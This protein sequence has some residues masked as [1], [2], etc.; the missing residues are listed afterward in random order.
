MNG[1]K[2]EEVIRSLI[3]SLQVAKIYTISHP[4][5]NDSI[6][7]TYLTFKKNLE[8]KK[9]LIIGI[10]GEEFATDREIFFELSERAKGIIE[11]FKSKGIE[12]IAFFRDLSKEELIK[13]VSF[14]TESGEEL[15]RKD[16]EKYLS[17]LGIKNIVIGKIK[18]IAPL[19]EKEEILDSINYL[20]N[21]E[22]SLQK[23]AQPVEAVISKKDF[24]EIDL[25]FTM[26]NIFEKLVGRY[27]EF[28]KLT[29][30]KK[31]DVVTFVHLLN[32]SILSMYFSKKC[33]FKKEEVIDI[34]MAGLFH[35][36][37]KIYISRRIVKK[38]EKLTKEEHARIKSHTTLG[39]EI[40]L[41]YTDKLGILSV[42]VAFEHHRR[43]DERGYPKVRFSQK[44]HLVSLI[45]SICDVYD[46]LLQRRDYKRDY[47]PD[48]VY[49]IMMREK[50]G[51]FS[52][53]LLDRFFQIMG[54]WPIG[55]ILL[56]S[57]GKICV[58]REENEDD[59][60]SP[61]VEVIFPPKEKEKIDLK[62]EKARIKIERFLNP[63]SEGKKY[64][65]LI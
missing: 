38:T 6:E 60:F 51:L 4:K 45:V 28:L 59:I 48:M 15:E 35:D 37:G 62:K 16:G 46:A 11:E 52:P 1:M 41:N 17:V 49:R 21:Y 14:L 31:Y 22:S 19:K 58:V 23:I 2:I 30:V 7:K 56:L 9:E 18:S 24:D 40:L 12:R 55:T 29:T 25:K 10:V 39:A 57:N 32:V 42:V 33:G 8:E 64:L 5:F 27:G 3:S 54:V 13:F 65:H 34:G 50:G 63:F 36:I 20:K 61:K 26:G 43:Y 53:S 44:P 47:P